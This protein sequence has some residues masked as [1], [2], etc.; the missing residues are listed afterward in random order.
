MK[1]LYLSL[2]A[3]FVF[4]PAVMQASERPTLQKTCD[5]RPDILVHPIYD[6]YVPYR[7][8]YN[9]PRYLGGWIASKI[10]P[11][12][13]E[14]MVWRDNLN[15]GRYEH[16]HCPP[17]YRRY[18]AP[19]PWEVLTIGARPDTKQPATIVEPAQTG[20]IQSQPAPLIELET[21]SPSD[22]R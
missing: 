22:R 16:K 8:E 19:K 21:P 9:R 10:A 14:A 3:I 20:A 17:M 18:F 2:A 7:K 6:A 4:S 12:S 11:S 15:A 5:P 1:K 13:Q